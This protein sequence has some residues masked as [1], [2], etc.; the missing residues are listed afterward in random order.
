M[1]QC[2][3]DCGKFKKKPV[4]TY[5]LKSGKVKSCGCL[6]LESNKGR[7]R[8]HGM[9]HSRLWHIWSSMHNRVKHHKLYAGLSV[10]DEWRSFE[11]FRSWALSSGYTDD[12]TIDRIDNSKGYSPSNCRWA[13]YKVQENNRRNNRIVTIHGTAHTLSEWSDIIGINPST[14]ANRISYGWND[15]ELFLPSDLG[16]RIKRRK[17]HAEHYSDH[18]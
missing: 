18:G 3:C 4:S 11:S 9:T 6:Y 2:K 10:C 5:C 15:D 17:F 16:N 14:L 13:T 1:W 8:R 12:L 7:N